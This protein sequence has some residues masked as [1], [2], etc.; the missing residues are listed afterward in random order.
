M[1]AVLWGVIGC[2]SPNDEQRFVHDIA[3]KR[4]LLQPLPSAGQV[5][6]ILADFERRWNSE[7]A[8]SQPIHIK[9]I[10]NSRQGATE[11]STGSAVEG[12]PFAALQLPVTDSNAIFVGSA[13]LNPLDFAKTIADVTGMKVELAPNSRTIIL[14]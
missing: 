1:I 6:D 2:V 11:A 4:I 7:F 9:V 13:I 14:Y 5:Q 12:D 3:D 8:S 10:N